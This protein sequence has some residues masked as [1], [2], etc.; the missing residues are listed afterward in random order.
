MKFKLKTPAVPGGLHYYSYSEAQGKVTYF[1]LYLS[2]IE[3]LGYC[4][5]TFFP[6]TECDGTMGWDVLSYQTEAK[7]WEQV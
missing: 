7:M 6:R 1:T 5:T 2:R 3:S 4:P